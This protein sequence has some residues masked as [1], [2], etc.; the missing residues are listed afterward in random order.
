[1]I[2]NLPPHTHRSMSMSYT[3]FNKRAQLIRTG[4]LC[5]CACVQSPSP[6]G[7]LCTGAGTTL[8]RNFAFG[9]STPRYRGTHRDGLRSEPEGVSGMSYLAR[10]KGEFSEKPLH[11]E[12]T[13][14]TEGAFVGF[15]SARSSRISENERD[16]PLAALALA[17]PP[18]TKAMNQDEREIVAWLHR[19]DETDPPF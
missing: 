11:S 13:K 2:F 10:L 6:T 12:L 16:E 8:D 15:V 5:A 7:V 3:R 1:M 18:A 14:L 17:N 19:I 4:A 9:A